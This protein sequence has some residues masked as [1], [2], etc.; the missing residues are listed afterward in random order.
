MCLQFS[1]QVKL[2]D[3]WLNVKDLFLY[4]LIIAERKCV[5]F[6]LAVSVF[7]PA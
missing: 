1:C 5:P 3:S 2:K 6:F 4:N 7:G